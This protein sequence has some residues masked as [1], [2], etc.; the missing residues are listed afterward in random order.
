MDLAELTEEIK[1]Q[2]TARFDYKGEVSIREIS[3]KPSFSGCM[4]LLTT[5]KV[6]LGYNPEYVEKSEHLEKIVAHPFKE[7]FTAIQ[8]HELNHKGG[9]N[10]QGC[11]RKIDLH[12][13]NIL[14]PVSETLRELG[15]PN[16]L[17]NENQ[18]LYAYM[19]N[20]IEDIFDNSELGNSSDHVGMFLC[21]K[22]D[23]ENSPHVKDKK[24]SPLFDAFVQLQQI[25]YGG[26][27]SRKLLQ[28]HYSGE[29]KVQTTLDNFMQ[30]SGLSELQKEGFTRKEE[31]KLVLDRKKAVEYCLD[32]TNWSELSRILTEEFA[33][34]ID[35]DKL[36]QPEYVKVTFTPLK[37]EADGFSDEMD[38]KETK[39]KF[40]WKKYQK[41][42]EASL[43]FQPPAYL[44]DFESLDLVYQRLARNLE[45]KTR[46]STRTTTMPIMWY[47]KREFDLQKDK[48][49]KAR[50]GFGKKGKLELSVK[51][52]H[53]DHPIE[54]TERKRSLPEIKFVMLDTSGSMAWPVEGDDSGMVM[55]PWADEER[56]WG[57]NSRYHHALVAWF[58]LQEL[59]RKQGTLKHTSVKLANYSSSTKTASNLREAR[60]LALT[61]QFGGTS[62]SMDAI[63]DMF[64]REQLVF[65]LSD[66]D[67]TNW[68][69]IKDDYI[70]RA[71]Q[72][73]Y[74]HLQIGSP[75][76]MSQDLENAGLVVKYDNGKNLG[77]LVIDLTRPYITRSKTK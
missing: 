14:E 13:E 77:K 24:L 65:S 26:K 48:L 71:K 49:S 8:R 56:Q 6:E 60:K 22:D 27:R 76:A 59:L 1:E 74:F 29:E 33:K 47:G 5:A 7:A 45:I 25:F 51:R 41:G 28:E 32:E 39:M 73:H 36:P 42:K 11:P 40:V 12:V 37:G 35:K 4:D 62:L 18:T 44:D 10:F 63:N 64:G 23:A 54:Y 55:N 15:F 53:E 50:V 75:T 3:K 70:K 16:M 31:K 20:L 67:V 21:Y 2:E 52:Y 34:L 17:V 19:A 72:N 69:S 30:R 46:A 66:G 9:G 38:H 57:N 43:G 68:S 58:G 61:P